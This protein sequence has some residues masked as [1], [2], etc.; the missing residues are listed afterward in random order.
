VGTVVAVDAGTT[1]VRSLLVDQTGV[2]VDVAYRELG[3]HFP[4][5]GWVE[6]DPAE[7]WDHVRSTLAELLSRTAERP[8]AIG[9]TNQRETVVAWDRNDGRPLRPAIV[10]Q[11]RRT[12]AR[13]HELADLGHLPLVRE[14]TGLVLDPYFSATKMEWLLGHADI[15]DVPGLALGTVDSWVLWN[16]TGGARRGLFATDVTNASRTMLF[17]IRRR[18]WSEDLMALFGVPLGALAEVR[19]SC[20]RFGTV[21]TDP[22]GA[23][24]LPVSAIAGD[25]QSA[26]FGQACFVRGMTKATYGTGSFILSNAGAEV[27][28]PTD[29][30]VTTIAWDLGEH[31]TGPTYALEGSTFVSGAAIQWLRDNLGVIERSEELGPLAESVPDSGGV[32]FVPAFTGLGSPWWDPA[33]RGTI[34]GLTRGSG[35]AQLARAVVESIAYSARAMV[36]A[37]AAASVAPTE[38]RVDGGAAAMDLLLQLQADQLGISVARPVAT[39]STALGAALM[40]GLAEG[41]WADLNELASLWTLERRFS[42]LADRTL[43]DHAYAQWTAA[44]QRSRHWA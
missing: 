27:P 40:A 13:C 1:G 25:Q 31:G 38:L 43:A 5:P 36:D 28:A 20:G 8:G 35:R 4:E 24:G 30:L 33:A 15:R 11:D 41:L 34:L 21:A 7:I 3:Q 39:E 2:V 19:P 44:V 17:D 9:I 22:A 12:A 42:P 14:T 37:M 29:G 6:H 26:L 16:L 32:S 18:Q 10:W 23:E